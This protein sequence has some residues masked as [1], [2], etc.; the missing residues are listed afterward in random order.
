M[1]IHHYW[2]PKK[3]VWKKKDPVSEIQIPLN[4]EAVKEGLVK[5]QMGG[6]VSSSRYLATRL[7]G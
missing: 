4:Y 2:H 1:L 5:D 3:K 6:K 7:F